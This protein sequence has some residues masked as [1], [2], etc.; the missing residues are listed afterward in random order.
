ME[1][2]DYNGEGKWSRA[3][4][5]KRYAHYANELGISPRD[6]LPTEHVEQRR[7][8][9]YPVMDKVNEGIEAGD[10]ACIRLGVEFLEE[11]AKFPFG[12]TLKANTAR[13]L[14]RA[15]LT[16]DQRFR[17]RRKVFGLLRDGHVP[18]HFREFARLVRKVGYEAAEIPD[19]DV[20]NPHA[21]RFRNYFELAIESD[22]RRSPT[23]E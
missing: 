22:V 13:A 3:E 1:V 18:R 17:I 14:R 6:L 7:R 8:W 19:V 5:L 10:Q 15:S 9:I 2:F 23:H 20:S 21:V 16:D 4:L 12:R 11:D